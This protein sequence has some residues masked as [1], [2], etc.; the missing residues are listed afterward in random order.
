M[1]FVCECGRSGRS[2]P[3]DGFETVLEPDRV[4][5]PGQTGHTL[6]GG[7]GAPD[8]GDMELTRMRYGLGCCQSVR[9]EGEGDEGKGNHYERR[10]K[11]EWWCF[12]KDN[13]TD[14]SAEAAHRVSNDKVRF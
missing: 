12:M 2:P 10:V 4:H 7:G 5:D 11:G 9:K 8:D 6:L 14:C 13:E 1:Y 3:V